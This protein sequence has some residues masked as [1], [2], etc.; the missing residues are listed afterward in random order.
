[1][2]HVRGTGDNGGLSWGW[3]LLRKRLWWLLLLL[4]ADDCA[5]RTRR[6]VVSREVGWRLEIT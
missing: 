6:G 2:R 5:E 3:L 4:G 1:V